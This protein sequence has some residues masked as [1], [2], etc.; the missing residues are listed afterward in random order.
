MRIR[1]AALAFCLLFAQLAMG[2]A[3]PNAIT[4]SDVISMTK[5]GIGE[6]TIILAIQRGPVK[7]D[8]S[9]EALIA[10]KAAGVSDNVL[11]AILAEKSVPSQVPSSLNV[12]ADALFEKVIRTLGSRDAIAAVHSVRWSAELTRIANGKSVSFQLENVTAYPD[13]VSITLKYASGAAVREVVTPDFSYRSNGTNTTAIP[14]TD[15]KAL[16][17][18]LP[19]DF[20]YIAQHPEQF[21]VAG[22]GTEASAGGAEELTVSRDAASIIWRVDTQ[23]DRILSY[24]WSGESGVQDVEL[25]DWRVVSGISIPF[26][27]HE[28]FSDYT[29]DFRITD[30]EVNPVID[31]QLFQRPAQTVTQG[32]TLRILQEQSVPYTQESGG[33]TSTSC[34]IVGTANTSAYAT[35]YGNSAYGN[36]TTNFNQRMDCNSYDTTIRWPHVLNVMFAQASDGNSYIIACDRAWRW[37]KCVPLRAGEVFSARFTGKGIEVQAVN[38]KGKEEHP[39][40]QVLQSRSWR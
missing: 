37:S 11:N 4:N 33:G 36:A 3:A 28:V 21:E 16:R 22:S 8:T 23:T 20:L 14:E 38:S 32:L 39:T 24:R 34:N 27:R 29:Q 25:S 13:R 1:F 40:Y 31:E 9:P 17:E 5:A 6:Q 15:L 19:F 18:R 35:A 26:E 7:F 10:L 12:T 30:Y 2:Q